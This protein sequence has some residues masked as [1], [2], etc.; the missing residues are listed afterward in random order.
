MCLSCQRSCDS[1]ENITGLKRLQAT[2]YNCLSVPYG[3]LAA[4]LDMWS[5]SKSNGTNLI[6]G[7]PIQILRNLSDVKDFNNSL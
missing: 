7:F 1:E 5:F 2:A 6:R 3:K 4:G